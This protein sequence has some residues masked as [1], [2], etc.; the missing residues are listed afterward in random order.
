MA[1]RRE[2]GL[3]KYLGQKCSWPKHAN[4]GAADAS[5]CEERLVEKAAAGADGGRRMGGAVG[6]AEEGVSGGSAAE[7][8][9]EVGAVMDS[10]LYWT[11][12][13]ET[14]VC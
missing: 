10:Y 3:A 8:A 14:K 4:H 12:V 11:N 1:A 9:G 13:I 7:S 5:L 6:G 2:F